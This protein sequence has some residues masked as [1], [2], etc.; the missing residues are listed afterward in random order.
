MQQ[1][2]PWKK[3]V[4]AVLHKPTRKLIRI[5][6]ALQPGFRPGPHLHPQP[7]EPAG[8][9]EKDCKALESTM[10]V[11]TGLSMFIPGKK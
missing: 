1:M 5:K 3:T 4:R 10:A 7:W 11:G 8:E 9:A 6:S 2:L